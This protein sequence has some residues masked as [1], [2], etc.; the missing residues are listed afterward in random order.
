MTRQPV[1]ATPHPTFTRRAKNSILDA[2]D[3]N[4]AVLLDLQ[5]LRRRARMRADGEPASND[6]NHRSDTN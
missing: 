1:P 2:G 3:L 6:G 5:P 4:D